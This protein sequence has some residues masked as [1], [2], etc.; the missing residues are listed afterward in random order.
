MKKKICFVA[1]YM[2]CGGTEKSLLS[3]LPLLDRNKYDI[4]LLLMKKK[5]DLLTE[6]PEDIK[7]H[8]IPLPKELEE[9]LLNSRKNALI[10]AFKKGEIIQVIKKLVA[11]FRMVISTNSDVGR[12][13]WYYKSI[14]NKIQEYPEMFDVV[15]DYMG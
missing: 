6:L 15:I 3:L 12:R 11:G 1:E 7:V 4:T 9:E 8:E 14:K 5:G 10:Q 13:L 2:L